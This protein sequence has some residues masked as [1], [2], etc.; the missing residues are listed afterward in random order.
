LARIEKAGKRFWDYVGKMFPLREHLGQ[1]QDTRVDP[2]IP[3]QI[4]FLSALMM[5]VL[6][7]QSLNCT[8]QVFRQSRWW[9]KVF[10]GHVPSDS[11]VGRVLDLVALSG[12]RDLVWNNYYQAIRKNML[13]VCRVGGFWVVAYDGHETIS[14]YARTCSQCCKRKVTTKDRTGKEVVRIQ[15]YHRYVASGLVGRG[16]EGIFDWE[17]VLPG[18]DEVAAMVRMMQRTTSHFSRWHTVATVDGLYARAPLIKECLSKGQ[19]LLA[20]LKDNC[21]ELLDEVLRLA[22]L[23]KPEV[24]TEGQKTVRLYDVPNV[25]LWG[26]VGHPIRG[27]VAEETTQESYY[28]GGQKKTRTV[29]STWVWITTLTSENATAK[30]IWKMGH[31]RWSLENR[32]FNVTPR[33]MGLNHC[34]KH[35]PNAMLAFLLIL[36]LAQFFLACFY[37][38]NL[39]PELQKHLTTKALIRCF[40]DDLP[41]AILAN[42]LWQPDG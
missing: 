19:H 40:Q 36:V 6:R 11:T 1:I 38:R 24:F 42:P 3:A 22:R 28:E 37:L 26:H 4:C 17:P 15:S 12:L 10:G 27:V 41:L 34:F 30:Q 14:S 13:K 23:Q 32:G 29:L 18:E 39:K 25:P 5:F 8:E 21:P 31:K 35:S 9:E 33:D 7:F 20:V 2:R 16:V